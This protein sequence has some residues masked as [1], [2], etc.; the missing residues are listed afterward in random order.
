MKVCIV[1]AGAIGGFIG[2]RLAKAGRADV[3]AVARGATLA[4]LQ[5]HG[6]RTRSGDALLQTKARA[7]D[8][9]AALGVQDL[10]IIAVKGPALTAVAQNIAPLLAPHTLVLPAM[11]GVPWWFCEGLA[12]IDAAPLQSVDPG[13]AVARPQ[14]YKTIER[15]QRPL[16]NT[17]RFPHPPPYRSRLRVRA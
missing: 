9:P 2:T 8:V 3:S 13:G 10:V 4:A 14:S 1:G 15:P 7:S 17:A 12:G 16:L 5:E 11:N 6:W